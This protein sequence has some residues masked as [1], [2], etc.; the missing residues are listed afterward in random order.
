MAAPDFVPG[1]RVLILDGPHKGQIGTIHSQ[2]PQMNLRH[3]L[4]GSEWYVEFDA[5]SGRLSYLVEQLRAVEGA[6]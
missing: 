4:G 2:H 6:A 1:Q 5:H 3:R